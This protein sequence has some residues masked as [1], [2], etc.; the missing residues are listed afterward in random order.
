MGR[1]TTRASLLQRLREGDD[2]AAWRGLEEMYRPL[3]LRICRA[4][5]LQPADAE[6]VVQNVFVKLVG[7]LRNFEYDPAKG[8]FRDYLFRSVSHGI[9]DWGRRT[10]R[11]GSIARL[12]GS[13]TALANGVEGGDSAEALERTMERE[14]VNHHYRAAIA[15]VLETCDP[16]G[17]EVFRAA[18]AGRS[19]REIAPAVGMTE[20]AVYKSLS[21]TKERLREAIAEQLRREDEPHA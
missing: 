10:G 12:S 15:T 19:V 17:V 1:I 16:R 3:L 7:G 18:I 11:Q 13:G 2:P 9:A 8:R 5:G 20:A 21:R 6:D 4:R 14:W